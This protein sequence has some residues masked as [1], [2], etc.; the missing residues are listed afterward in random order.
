MA[1]ANTHGMKMK[2]TVVKNDDID[3]CLYPHHAE[4][5]KKLL[6]WLAVNKLIQENNKPHTYLVIN[7]DEDYADEIIEILKRNG[8]WG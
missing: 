3:K 8:H 6:E 5:L 2:Y 1:N 4:E 7:T